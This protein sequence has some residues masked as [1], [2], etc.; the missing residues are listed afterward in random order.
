MTEALVLLM[1]VAALTAVQVY[2]SPLLW[3]LWL[4]LRGRG[5]DAGGRS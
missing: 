3:G 1:A 2:L 4:R 5:G